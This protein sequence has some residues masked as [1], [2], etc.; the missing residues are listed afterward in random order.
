MTTLH[1]GAY[2]RA[3]TNTDTTYAN[4]VCAAYNMNAGRQF[5]QWWTEADRDQ[6]N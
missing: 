1:A 2:A 6:D 3:M 5:H 4:A